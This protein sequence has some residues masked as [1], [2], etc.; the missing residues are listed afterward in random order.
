M[1]EPITCV[2]QMTK[3]L[4]TVARKERKGNLEFET[5]EDVG[6]VGGKR[7]GRDRSSDVHQR[8]KKL[9]CV[10]TS[11]LMEKDEKEIRTEIG[12]VLLET[13][14]NASTSQLLLGLLKHTANAL[15]E[16]E[17]LVRTRD[18]NVHR[19]RAHSGVLQHGTGP[20]LDDV[21]EVDSSRGELVNGRS[22]GEEGGDDVGIEGRDGFFGGSRSEKGLGD[23]AGREGDRVGGRLG[24]EDR[25]GSRRG[26]RRG[27]REDGR[28]GRGRND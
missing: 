9:A 3:N 10:F 28:V 21:A 27:R 4:T 20:L 2:Y 18:Q 13:H 22:G 8:M 6:G 15:S 19:S 14:Y 1:T 25:G 5:D 26:G 23:G 12:S 7:L 16:I 17:V 24:R 11:V